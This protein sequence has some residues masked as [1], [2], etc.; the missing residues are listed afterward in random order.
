M[1]TATPFAGT[2]TLNAVAVTA[3]KINPY[4]SGGIPREG[5]S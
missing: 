4:G 1:F 2:S 3:K 5:V